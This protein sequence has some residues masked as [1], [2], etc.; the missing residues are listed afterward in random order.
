MNR[1]SFFNSLLYHLFD[2][3]LLIVQHLNLIKELRFISGIFCFRMN[4][5]ANR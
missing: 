1:K 5:I 3:H 2:E 4:M